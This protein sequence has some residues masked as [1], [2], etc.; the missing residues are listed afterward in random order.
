M[1]RLQGSLRTQAGVVHRRQAVALGWSVDEVR[2]QVR[3]GSWRAIYPG[4]YATFTGAP[5]LEARVWAALLHAGPPAMA[6]HLTA[7]R[8]QGL[9]D[10]DPSRIQVS[11]PNGHRATPQPGLRIHRPRAW[12]ERRQGAAQIP[13]TRV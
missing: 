12:A 6:S 9:V 3:R 4:V 1:H 2:Q 10:E 11:V 5:T 13:Q 8:L 7:A